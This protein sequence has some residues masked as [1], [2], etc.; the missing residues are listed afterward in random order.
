M[1][2]YIDGLGLVVIIAVVFILRQF[3]PSPAKN[4]AVYTTLALGAFLFARLF[5]NYLET[6]SKNALLPWIRQ[7]TNKE[8]SELASR[9]SAL[10]NSILEANKADLDGKRLIQLKE[11]NSQIYAL[12]EGTEYL[13]SLLSRYSIVN[14]LIGII[15][16]CFATGIL[17]DAV[18][19]QK[20]TDV[21]TANQY[22]L[23]ILPRFALAIF[24][25]VFSFFFLRLYKI[26][27]E[28]VK[29]FNNERTNIDS[30]LLSLRLSL[31]EGDSEKIGEIITVLSNVERNFILKK[32]ETSIDLER[33][34]IEAKHELTLLSRLNILEAMKVFKNKEVSSDG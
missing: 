34:K 23:Q 20:G 16:T 13:Q 10:E 24:I 26:N 4:I 25:E 22:L 6:G 18:L 19:N 21:L 3:C 29:Y 32:D 11:L 14:L 30:K 12:K 9:I 5:V 7:K 28:D 33:R 17:I 27:L 2:K 1:G 15:A 8:N 31:L